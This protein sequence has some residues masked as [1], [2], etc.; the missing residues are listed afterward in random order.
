MGR[1]EPFGPLADAAHKGKVR[2]P[3]WAGAAHLIA[4]VETDLTDTRAHRANK[5][6][7]AA[8]P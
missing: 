6:A 3:A 8:S 2:S 1:R 5:T 7:E 4:A